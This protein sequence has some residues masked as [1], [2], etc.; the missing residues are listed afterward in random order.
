M[1]AVTGRIS[2]RDMGSV[3]TDVKHAVGAMNLPPGSYVEYGGLYHEQQ[4]SFRGLMGVFV[5]A[6]L[7]LFTLLLY[8]YERFSAPLAILVVAL[9]ARRRCSP[10]CGGRAPSSTSRP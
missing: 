10:G 9:L 7:L 1:V 3:M 2:G 6:V 4:K 8:L 5:A